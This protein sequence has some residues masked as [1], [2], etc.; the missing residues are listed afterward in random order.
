MH[1]ESVV[2]KSLESKSPKSK[3]TESYLPAS[4]EALGASTSW[5]TARLWLAVLVCAVIIGAAI[6]YEAWS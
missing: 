4:A 3:S 2:S 5:Q 1:N 6:A